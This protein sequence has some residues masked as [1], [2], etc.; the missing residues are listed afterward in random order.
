MTTSNVA[1]KIEFLMKIIMLIHRKTAILVTIYLFFNRHNNKKTL[2]ILN[3]LLFTHIY[4]IWDV[5]LFMEINLCIFMFSYFLKSFLLII[6][7]LKVLL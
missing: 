7:T 3:V 5:A 4:Q 1:P 2:E 6:N